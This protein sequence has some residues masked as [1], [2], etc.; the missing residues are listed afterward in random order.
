[1]TGGCM[2]GAVRYQLASKPFDC[3]WCHC[4]TCQLFG[5]APAMPFATIPTNH[6]EWTRGADKVRGFQSSSFGQRE[7][8]TECGT[9]LRVRVDHQPDTVDFPVVT[10]DEPA[11]VPPEFHIFWSSK[12]AWFEPG[13]ELPRHEKFRPGTPGLEG[14][15]P[16]DNSSLAGGPV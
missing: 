12:I 6:W 10:L 16:P 11:A 14:T 9:P 7:F 15:E 3:G 4:R 8:C 2:C 13:D 1:M 5:G